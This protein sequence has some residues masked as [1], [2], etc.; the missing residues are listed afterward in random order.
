L[1][2]FLKWDPC[3]L[4]IFISLDDLFRACSFHLRV[5]LETKIP[6]SPN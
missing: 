1:S 2:G 5:C 4:Y 3:V 6:P